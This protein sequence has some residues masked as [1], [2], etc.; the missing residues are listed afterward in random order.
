VTATTADAPAV[1]ALRQAC[2]LTLPWN[3]PQADF[4]L[5]LATATSNILVTRDGASITTRLL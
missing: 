2:N 5:A 3:D 4:D 1:I